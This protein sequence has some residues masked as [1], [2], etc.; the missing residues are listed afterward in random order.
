MAML[1]PPE[2]SVDGVPVIGL[3]SPKVLAL[4]AYLAV[5]AHHPHSR[6]ALADLLWPDQTEVNALR[7]LRKTLSR[8]RIAIGDDRADPPHLLADSLVIQLNRASH[9][10]LDV[11]CFT[12][13]LDA[14]RHHAHRRL[15]ACLPCTSLLERA[16]GCYRGDFLA[17]LRVEGCSAA[18]DEWLMLNRERLRLRACSALHALA[19]ASLARGEHAEARRYAQRLVHLDPLSEAAERL[20][21]RALALSDGRNAALCHYKG[22]Q[23]SRA[24]ELGVAPEDATQALVQQVRAGTLSDSLS[25]AASEHLPLP[26]TPLVG[27]VAELQRI[28]EYLA[29]RD[30][31][32][33]TLHGLGGSGKTRLAL[34]S[35]TKQ[36]HLWRDGVWFVPLATVTTPDEL[37]DRLAETLAH[38]PEH[39]PLQPEHLMEDLRSREL[40]LILDGFEHLMDARSILRKILRSAEGVRILVTS[41]SRLGLRQEWS[42]EVQGL[43]VPEDLARLQYSAHDG[44]GAH[45][46]D[47]EPASGPGAPSQLLLGTASAAEYDAVRLFVQNARQSDPDF[48]LTD[49]NL[50]HVVR[51]CRLVSGLPLGIE[52]AAAWVR[53]YRCHRIA[54]EIERSPDFLHRSGSGAPEHQQSL[55]AAFEYAYNLL[56]RSER[57]VFRQ[58]SVFH[59]GFTPRAALQVADAGPADLASLADKSVLKASRS[60]RLDTHRAVRVY[61]AEKLSERP[62]EEQ[63][64]RDRHARFFLNYMQL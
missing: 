27:R 12:S 23:Q 5:E 20:M 63:M 1:G 2:V 26:G 9:C 31:R 60:G 56:T 11:E 17:A 57:S 8:L 30:Q 21:L 24:D 44:D 51:I 46:A 19:S 34:E 29:G 61:A 7:N 15:E 55:R 10:H 41:R 22:F 59:G 28:A 45:D 33:V 62:D 3:R 14:T 36:A 53:L 16:C 4:M 25:S 48:L 32:L 43:S 54:D 42:I 38:A 50:P 18:F 47:A 64:A 58:L 35:A 40:L 13:C 49:D 39:V 37:L 52:L 6:A